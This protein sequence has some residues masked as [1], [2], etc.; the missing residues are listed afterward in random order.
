MHPAVQLSVLLL[1]FVLGAGIQYSR[2]AFGETLDLDLRG[3]TVQG[4]QERR[5]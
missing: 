4:V 5:Y 3:R 2:T 1:L